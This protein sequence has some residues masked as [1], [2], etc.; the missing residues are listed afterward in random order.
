MSEA[1]MDDQSTSDASAAPGEPN[2]PK[3]RMDQILAKLRQREEELAM[4]DQLLTQLAPRQ[5]VQAPSGPTAEE[6]GLEPQVFQAVQKIAENM[7]QQ[8]LGQEGQRIKHQLAAIANTQEET[9][10][11]MKYGKDKEAYLEKIKLQRQRHYQ[12]TGSYLSV[13]NAYKLVQFD[14]LT[15]RTQP[16]AAAASSAQPATTD[17]Q[18]TSQAAPDANQTRQSQSAPAAPAKKQ[19]SDMTPEEQEVYLDSQNAGPF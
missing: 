3:W 9:Q 7:V 8:R 14:E 12:E 11:L 2:V 15:R 4:K 17:E 18:P 19:F 13:E 1:V 5:Q 6:L 16:K 10:F